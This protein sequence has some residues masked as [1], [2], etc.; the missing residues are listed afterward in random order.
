MIFMTFDM[1]Q[2]KPGDRLIRRDGQ[3]LIYAKLYGRYDDYKHVCHWPLN[4]AS[5]EYYMNNGN[6]FKESVK[7]D[8]WD[9]VGFHPDHKPEIEPKSKPVVKP[10]L[11]ILGDARHGKDT[12]AQILADCWGLKFCSSSLFCAEK[13]IMPVL[14]EKY[15]YKTVQECF[16]DRVNHRAEWKELIFSYN[17]DDLTRLSKSI[18][19][20][21]DVYVGMREIRELDACKAEGLFDLIVWVDD[22]YRKPPEDRSSMTITRN[23]ADYIVWNGGDINNL[24]LEAAKMM[25]F[26]YDKQ[27]G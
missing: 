27:K 2:C 16:D 12:F 6:Y 13:V 14:A 3:E 24:I 22:G 26:Y 15:G 1:T 23:V 10:K 4:A 20:E 8:A 5:I 21:N 18:L 7:P 9:I 11:L 17:Q 19:A 25:R